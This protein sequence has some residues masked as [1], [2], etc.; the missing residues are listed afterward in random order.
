MLNKNGLIPKLQ[1]LTGLVITTPGCFFRVGTFLDLRFNPFEGRL[2][3]ELTLLK[4]GVTGRSLSK[5][6][7]EVDTGDVLPSLV[8]QFLKNW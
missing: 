2:Q 4:S 1:I 8:F 7:H 3:T 6:S 5:S